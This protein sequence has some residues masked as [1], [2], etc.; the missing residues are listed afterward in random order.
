MTTPEN[1]TLAGPIRVRR[2]RPKKR[3]LFVILFIL[4]VP[5]ASFAFWLNRELHRP[6]AHAKANDYIEIPRRSTPEGIV[7]KLVSEG[8]LRHKWPLLLYIKLTR[9]AKLLKA[10][11]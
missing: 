11:E 4:V 6:I 3:W 5:S 10:G 2:R 8:V 9:S 1:L 7:N